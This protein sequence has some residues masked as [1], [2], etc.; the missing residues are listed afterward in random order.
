M[1]DELLTIFPAA[2]IVRRSPSTLR[3]WGDS[4]KVKVIRTSN[5]MRLFERRELEEIR[6][7]LERE[8]ME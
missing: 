4:G 5:G 3:A 7:R 8:E 6:A 1:G 2:Q